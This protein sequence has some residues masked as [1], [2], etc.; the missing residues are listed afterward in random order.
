[1]Q[2]K[3]IVVGR[4]GCYFFYIVHLNHVPRGVSVV[5]CGRNQ[6]NFPESGFDMCLYC[7]SVQNVKTQKSWQ[8]CQCNIVAFVNVVFGNR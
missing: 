7:A 1:M 5:P 4:R 8:A 2:K 3:E 6:V